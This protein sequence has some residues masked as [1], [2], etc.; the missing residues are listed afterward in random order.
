MP[1]IAILLVLQASVIVLALHA[2]PPGAATSLP[3]AAAESPARLDGPFPIAERTVTLPC[4]ANSDLW[5]NA[6]RAPRLL[7]E[8]PG[9]HWQAEV[10]IVTRGGANTVTGLATYRDR[11]NW[12]IWGV[13]SDGSLDVGGLLGGSPR[14]SLIHVSWP[15]TRLRVVRHGATYEF[16]AR[17]EGEWRRA[18]RFE[19][20]AGDLA[21]DP[22]VGLIAKSWRGSAGF[23]AAFRGWECVGL[24]R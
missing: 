17:V 10:E 14:P 16:H 12:L 24:P 7:V 23:D 11:A 20:V 19:D 21:A 3:V 1:R 15:A 18:G 6:D 2:V 13:L 5:V 8:A 22:R 4:P 9:D